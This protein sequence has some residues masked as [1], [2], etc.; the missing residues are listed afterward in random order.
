MLWTYE[1]FKSSDMRKPYPASPQPGEIWELNCQ[2]QSPEVFSMN[3]KND[4]YSPEAQ[5]FL[6]G[7]TPKRYVMIVTETESEW[8]ILSVMVLSE[9]ISF[10]SDVDLLIPADISG[11][12]QDLLAE[13]WHVQP[14]LAC[15]LLQPMG[16]RLSHDIYDILLTVGDC[17]HGLINQQLERFQFER[18]GLKVGDQKALEIPKIALFHKQEQAWS[19]VLT[20]PVAVYRTY[21][22]SVNF[23]SQILREQLQIDQELAK[24]KQSQNTSFNS[25]FTSFNKTY[26]ILSRWWQNIFEPEWQVFSSF[27]N[28]A[29]ATRSHADLQNTH[30]NPDEIAALVKQLSSDNEENQ[31]QH[32][33]KRLGE[34]AIGHLD[35]IQALVNLLR[36]TSDDETLWIAVESLRKIDPENPSNGV[37][38]VKLVDLGMDIAGKAVAL[39]VA[40]LQKYDGNVSVLLQVYP[41]GSD[42]YL[43][44]DLKLILLDGSGEILREV[45]ARRADVYTQLKFSCELGERFTVQVSLGNANFSEDFVI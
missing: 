21:I 29:I 36:S 38:R 16:K 2:V 13:T 30:S 18:L 5:N 10:I 37:R 32:A 43:P 19:D 9:E 26:I 11:L 45:T 23:T 4:L 15:N 40:L 22:K 24:F 34:I 35:A 17:Y 14:M 42:R 41:T 1:N 12:S 6:Q 28:L 3:T 27:P 8:G 7:S 31:R 25:L 39:S 33:A 44:P 20:I